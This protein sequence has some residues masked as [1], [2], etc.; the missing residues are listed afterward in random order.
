MT[1]SKTLVDDIF[2]YNRK[3][4]NT[5]ILLKLPPIW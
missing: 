3:K 1:T 5:P 2:A 4:N